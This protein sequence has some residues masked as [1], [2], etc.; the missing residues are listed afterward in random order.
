MDPKLIPIVRSP[1]LARSMVAAKNGTEMFSSER[2][3]RTAYIP[4]D[5]PVAKCIYDRVSAFQGY[6][7]LE[8]IE[9]LQVTA[10]QQDQQY[11]DH[12]DWFGPKANVTKDR[13]TTFFGVLEADCDN[14]G[15]NF[16]DLPVSWD[17]QDERWCRFV[18]CTASSVTVLPVPGS[19]LFWKNLHSDGTG[20]RRMRHAGL[21]LTRGTKT[22]LNIWTTQ[23]MV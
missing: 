19:A 3:S 8:N 22:G 15:T 11:R 5:D 12:F 4:K 16:P 9:S 2:S 21:P 1:N 14:C 7:P 13:I 17:G 10:Y 23:E 18:D 20:D 6:E